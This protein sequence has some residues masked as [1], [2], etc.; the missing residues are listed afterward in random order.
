MHLLVAQSPLLNQINTIQALI[1][2]GDFLEA[3]TQLHTAIQKHDRLDFDLS[4]AYERLSYVYMQLGN[5]D[6]ARR[7]N[8]ESLQIREQFQYEFIAIHY[9]RSGTLD[10]IDG[11][12]EQAL[13]H[14]KRAE[15]LPHEDLAFSARLFGY[16]SQTY[17]RLG[18]REEAFRY[19][20]LSLETLRAEFGEDHPEMVTCYYQLGHL[21][22]AQNSNYAADSLFQMAL[23][24]L[25]QISPAPAQPLTR[26][27]LYN[28][29]A[30]A[31]DGRMMPT[32]QVTELHNL[33]IKTLQDAGYEQH[34]AIARTLL[35]LAQSQFEK[36]NFASAA[37]Y[38]DRA[39]KTLHI[40]GRETYPEDDDL[41]SDYSLFAQAHTLRSFILEAMASTNSQ[42]LERAFVSVKKGLKALDQILSE[43]QLEAAQMRLQSRFEQAYDQGV[44]LAFSLYQLT[45]D[46][47]FAQEAFV[48][49]EKAK[50]RVLRKALGETAYLQ[51]AGISKKQIEHLSFLKQRVHFYRGKA[52]LPGS[53]TALDSLRYFQTEWLNARSNIQLQL[54]RS[55][56]TP[57]DDSKVIAE[58]Q[59]QIPAQTA[60]LS[61]FLTAQ[62]IYI[63]GLTKERFEVQVTARDT[64]VTQYN[65]MQ[66]ARGINKWRQKV[67]ERTLDS[68]VGIYKQFG[69]KKDEQFEI[70]RSVEE[71]I[72][73]VRKRKK[74]PFAHYSR[75]LYRQ[76]ISP[77]E[78]L[79]AQKTEL[80]IIPHAELFYLPFEVLLSKD[81]N[82][83]VR[84]NKLEY[85]VKTFDV[86]Y[87]H[88]AQL[89]V[90]GLQK[91]AAMR[92]LPDQFLGM[93]PVF[94][95]SSGYI[96]QSDGF[97]YDTT[98][99]DDLTLRAVDPS[100][101]KW[102][103]L[104]FSESELVSITQ[105]M[106]SRDIPAKSFLHEE[107]T[108]AAFKSFASE[109]TIIH[110]A[111]HS[112][113]NDIDMNQSGIA[114]AYDSKTREDGIL[115][116]PECQSLDLNAKLVV[117]S[118]C[119]SA[120]GQLHR[121]EGLLS[122]TRGFLTNQTPNII[123]SLWRV[124]DQH[125]AS[126]MLQFYK[127]VLEG[128]SYAQSLR[129]TKLKMIRN[130]KTADPMKWA[131]FVLIG[132]D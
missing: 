63:F 97:R 81:F 19:A 70:S 7:Y 132:V 84:Y 36:Q 105:W 110:L 131:G 103:Q 24:R 17:I 94:A 22:A 99:T 9:M 80:A 111:T 44:R 74:E 73:N 91:Y 60:L 61:Y 38:T 86:K 48:I 10:L 104:D 31:Q 16:L 65:P 125:T 52:V 83:K 57:E 67:M 88:S 41:Y 53:D 13:L 50:G 39:I 35:F 8:Q 29:I 109:Y 69:R 77:M 40:A 2:E 5:T 127:S 90:D 47:K 92:Q 116:T 51:Q 25:D 112:F 108:E 123:A 14:L 128:E 64:I 114:F 62:H 107:A 28:A 85:L 124:S 93:A 33:A 3:Q 12:Y 71:L 117:L 18:D 106:A 100:G 54:D 119:E 98:S 1:D 122:L 43:N 129:T 72:R 118:S 11:R 89:Y 78:P 37:G 82:K 96:L 23:S 34:P 20:D 79:I 58:I 95:D 27:Q 120:L 59:T 45:G 26:A 21:Y 4:D 76:L 15:D 46:S 6:R 115:Y 75:A 102:T 55:L 113:A 66:Y 49:S 126:L 30:I 32:A 56:K 121:G 68:G 130:S 42:G 101:R 87:H